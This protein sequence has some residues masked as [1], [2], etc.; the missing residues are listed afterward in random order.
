MLSTFWCSI[1]VFQ[2]R[3]LCSLNK[4][5]PSTLSTTPHLLHTRAFITLPPSSKVHL[6]IAEPEEKK[7]EARRARERAQKRFQILT[8]EVDWRVAEAYVALAEDPVELYDFDVKTKESGLRKHGEDSLEAM[9][10]ERYLDDSEWEDNERR[11]GRGIDIRC[12]P[13]VRSSSTGLNWNSRWFSHR[14]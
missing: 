9:A 13:Y 3:T 6:G 8:K 14:N 12:F 4:L 2:G 10:V 5:P 7:R 11:H 1:T